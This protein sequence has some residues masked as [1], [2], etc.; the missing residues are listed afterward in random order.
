MLSWGNKGTVRSL[1]R[2]ILYGCL[3]LVLAWGLSVG[4][5]SAHQPSRLNPDRIHN[6]N[7]EGQQQL[8]QGNPEA[9]LETWLEAEKLYRQM[10]N[11]QGAM[12][13]QIN[14]AKALQNL[15]FYRRARTLLDQVVAFQ[16]QQ[17]NSSLKAN[18]LLTLG[19]VLRLIG[20]YEKSQEVLTESLRIAQQMNSQ[21]DLQAAYLHLGNT[22][23]AQGQSLAA[24]DSF[25]QAA[26]I[27]GQLKLSAQLGQLK[28]FGQL[29]RRAEATTLQSQIESHLEVLPPGQLA[30]YGR[31][32]FA[33]LITQG[34]EAGT[35]ESAVSKTQTPNLTGVRTTGATQ[36]LQAANLLATAA[37]QARLLGDR[38]AESYA[39]GRLGH[40]YEQTRQW[41]AAKQLTQAA[42][43][44]A[45]S[46][47]GTEVLYQWQ[48][49]MGRILRSQG[50][51]PGATLAYTQAVET[52]QS[53]RQDLV[54]IGQD[55]QFSFRDQVEP[56]YRGLVDLLLQPDASQEHLSKAR[57]VL[58]SLQLVELNNFFREACLDARVRPVDH[59]APTAA[60]IYPVLLPDRLEIIVSFPDKRLQQY[61]TSVSEEKILAGIQ[62]MQAS[63]RRTSFLQERLAAAQQLHH[64]LI[65]PIATDLTRQGVQTLVFVLDGSLR[66]LPMAALHDGS[67][68]LI[69]QYQIALAP[70]L[71]LLN[72]HQLRPGEMRALVGGLSEGMA[73]ATPLPGVEQEVNEI[74]Q[75]IPTRI[76]LNQAFTTDALKTQMQ[77]VPFTV[78]HFATH[79]QFSSNARDTY[80]QTW[81]GRLTVTDLQDLLNQR[82]L[83]DRHGIDLLVLSACQTAVGDNRATLGMAGVAVRSGA[84][85]TLAT[86]WRVNDASTAEFVTRFYQALVQP[87]S[88]KAQA[89]RAAQM[90]MIQSPAFNHP[91]YWAPFILVGNWL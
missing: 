39:M 73:G 5:T 65:Q 22:L 68:Y 67:H 54:A 44:R 56:V 86:L 38:R 30:I 19:N 59:V 8:D 35:G 58:E 90:A 47:N 20:E 34:A 7:L 69:E 49:Q 41:V 63:F 61:T 18:G 82:S 11:L 32:E 48:W 80:I 88:N 81:D 87:G 24:L 42:L 64:W 62:A 43:Q 29:H 26:A 27:P 46:V 33:N 60:V 85:S 78:I 50:D 89:V 21:P 31:I 66:N 91:F 4:D 52:L 14:Q 83:T 77:A 75:Q 1:C 17:P 9:A 25:T 79:G 15:G 2:L 23:L 10:G 76:L 6:L 28:L 84:R 40:L 16:R 72:P 13:T 74:R 55:V 36:M 45:K 12:G 71:Q 3:G 51:V 70:S 57:Q 53:L 37:Q